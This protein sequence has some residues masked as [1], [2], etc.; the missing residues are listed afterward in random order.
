MTQ[1]V[2]V[3]RWDDVGAPQVVD[4]RPSEYIEIFKKCLVE[5]YGTKQPLGWTIAEESTAPLFIAFQNDT[6]S[7]GTG[8]T[9]MLDAPDNS[10]DAVTKVQSALDFAGQGSFTRGGYYFGFDA[11]SSSANFQARNWVLIGTGKAFYIYAFTPLRIDQ[12]Y[13]GTYNCI[14]FFAGDINSLYPNDSASFVAFSGEI[15]TVRTGW[16][17][18]LNYKLIDTAA[19]KLFKLYP[20][21]G[22]ALAQDMTL[23]NIF[24]RYAGNGNTE[25]RSL[26]PEI[27]ML[28]P[29]YVMNLENSGS[30]D[31]LNDAH[32][33]HCRG[34][35]PGFFVS[36]EAGYRD[37]G[38]QPFIKTIDNQQYMQVP[39]G[40]S[41][42]SSC[43][44]INLEG[45]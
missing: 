42:R 12:N 1:Q 41:N 31:F 35:L 17:Y 40:H 2:T 45:W 9:L 21:D 37:V 15:D 32:S 22:G 3:Y 33:P 39:P 7:G 36:Q 20:M 6:A 25:Y 24:G 29:M 18:N 13:Q 26:Q 4:G 27:T 8:G 10:P 5:G 30:S 28:S 19:S 38:Y 23:R 43:L 34:I 16:N 44:W 14:A 11:G